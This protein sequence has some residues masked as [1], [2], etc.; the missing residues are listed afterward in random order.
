MAL[1]IRAPRAQQIGLF[2]AL[3]ANYIWGGFREL[4]VMGIFRVIVGVFNFH[5]PD[6]RREIE[7]TVDTGATYPVIPRTLAQEL[8]ID[9]SGSLTLTLADGCQVQRDVGWVG[10]DCDGR[11]G[12]CRAV[13]G[14]ADDVPLLGAVA[15]QVLGLEVDPVTETLRPATLYLL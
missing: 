4:E 13:F 12:P 5:R 2:G 15:L 7:M 9:P 14:K 11:S 6:D 10:L 8:G 1:E 3:E